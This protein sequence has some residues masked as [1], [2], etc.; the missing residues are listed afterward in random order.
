MSDFYFGLISGLTIGF[1]GGAGLF[2]IIFT[3][4]TELRE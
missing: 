1:A 2:A 4:I 3:G